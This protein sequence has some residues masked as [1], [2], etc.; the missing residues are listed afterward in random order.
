M[1]YSQNF[2]KLAD[3][4]GFKVK[5]A[6]M[7]VNGQFTRRPDILSVTYNNHHLMTIPK[8]MYGQPNEKYKTLEGNVQPMFYECEY[9]I[10]NWNFLVK[11]TPHIQ[12]LDK[13]K[14]DLIA[15]EKTL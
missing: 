3:K 1:S 13:K 6:C 9:K 15:L 4:Y 14:R 5:P 7:Y 10:K 8:K 12:A 11:R 2:Q